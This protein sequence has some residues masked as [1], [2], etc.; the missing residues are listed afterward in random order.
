MRTISPLLLVGMLLFGGCG[1]S[2]GESAAPRTTQPGSSILY[3]GLSGDGVVFVVRRDGRLT[4]TVTPR[5]RLATLDALR[6]A[7]LG[8]RCVY[9]APRGRTSRVQELRN[10]AFPS[11]MRSVTVRP[12]FA[13]ARSDDTPHCTLR[14]PGRPLV[15]QAILFRPSRW[16]PIAF[17]FSPSESELTVTLEAL[18]VAPRYA[19]GI[20]LRISGPNR[21]PDGPPD[22]VGCRLSWLREDGFYARVRLG[23]DSR[24]RI[25]D[26]Q[27]RSTP[28]TLLIPQ[29]S[30]CGFSRRSYGTV[31]DV[32][33]RPAVFIAE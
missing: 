10:V 23:V 16:S 2:Y 18:G 30:L 3:S 6:G 25:V 7:G 28:A 20:R 21:W 11:R 22:A 29:I 24:D 9:V 19:G 32:P 31:L 14:R 15:A 1:G 4:I 17:G 12:R 26:L 27:Q 33:M 13:G 5:A 8:L